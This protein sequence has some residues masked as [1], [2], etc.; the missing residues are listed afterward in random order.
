[1]PRL[2]HALVVV[3]WLAG[4]SGLQAQDLMRHVELTSPEMTQSELTQSDIEHLIRQ[5][6]G[7]SLNLSGKRLLLLM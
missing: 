4:A 7:G 6:P 2:L 1:V 3:C 5:E